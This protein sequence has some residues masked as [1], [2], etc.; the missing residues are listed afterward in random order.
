V[1]DMPKLKS[2]RRHPKK[3]VWASEIRVKVDKET[4]ALRRLIMLV[5]AYENLS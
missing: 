5:R 2:D 3:D 1:I 4:P